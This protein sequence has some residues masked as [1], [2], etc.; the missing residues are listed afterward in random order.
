ALGV[1]AEF[2]HFGGA[3]T[4]NT[5]WYRNYS[6]RGGWTHERRALGHPLGGHGSGV[7]GRASLDLADA[8]L[9]LQAAT[10]LFDRGAENL[11]APEREGLAAG[12][13]LSARW[14]AMPRLE[15]SAGATHEDGAGWQETT[16]RLQLDYSFGRLR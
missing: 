14:R 11:Y 2:V 1:S 8:R 5:I 13:G 16:A 10:W 15:M 7:Y 4:K 6:L 12:T 9:R 3:S